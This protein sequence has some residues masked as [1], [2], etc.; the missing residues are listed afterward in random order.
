MCA[1]RV[2]TEHPCLAGILG[3]QILKMG[4]PEPRVYWWVPPKMEN[5]KLKKGKWKRKRRLEPKVLTAY[6]MR[7]DALFMSLSMY[8]KGGKPL[9]F[10]VL[11]SLLGLSAFHQ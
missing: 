2:L 6:E 10:V 9:R 7:N 8:Q 3:Q 4:A 11:P 1:L 5:G